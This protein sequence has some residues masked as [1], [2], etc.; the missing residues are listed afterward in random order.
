MASNFLNNL[1]NT[2]RQS[3]YLQN[4]FATEQDYLDLFDNNQVTPAMAQAYTPTNDT[5]GIKS[6][7]NT[8]PTII[9]QGGDDDGPTGPTGFN[10]D[11]NL[12]TSDYQGTDDGTPAGGI[13]GTGITGQGLMAAL[14][15]ALNPV[16]FFVGRYAKDT[17]KAYK[18]KKA[19]EEAAAEQ[20]ALDKAY[21]DQMAAKGSTT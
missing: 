15:F 4:Q 11:D 20:A 9:N 5:T 17:Y 13:A 10:R 2:Y 14:S 21:A 7:T 18:E 12:G 8:A 1:L 6:I 16:G 19:A 3:P